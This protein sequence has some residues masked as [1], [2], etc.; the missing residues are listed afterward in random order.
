MKLAWLG[1]PA[2]LVLAACCSQK[3][4]SHG[5]ASGSS[6]STSENAPGYDGPYPGGDAQSA[7]KGLSGRTVKNAAGQEWKINWFAVVPNDASRKG[8]GPVVQLEREG[9]K[10]HLPIESDGDAAD[11]YRRVTGEDHP[12]VKGTPEREYLDG[13]AKIK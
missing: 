8:K 1:L 7:M 12:T 11:F 4:E 10:R 6:H 2:L 5:A 9:V 13:W 3:E